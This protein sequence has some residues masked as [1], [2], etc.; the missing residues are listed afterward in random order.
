MAISAAT[1]R[2]CGGRRS[3]A[4]PGYGRAVPR[5][6]PSAAS[7]PGRTRL[8]RPARRPGPPPSFTTG[9]VSSRH[10]AI[11]PSSRSAARRAGTCTDQ[12]SRCSSTSI[13]G[14]RVLHPEP[15][16]D[17]VRDPGQRPALIQIAGRRR[18]RIQHR[19]QL[20]Q[21]GGS[22]HALRSGRP[23]GGQRRPAASAQGPP[24]P[25]HRHPRHPEPLRDLPVA[26][27]VSISSAAA[28][29]TCS[30]RDRSAAVS[31]PPSG[32][33]MPPAYPTA[34]RSSGPVTPAIEGR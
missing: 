24:P 12:P 26:G 1:T 28:S 31:P 22:E 2:A 17:L 7:G 19:L 23:F 13:P 15:P 11:L 8:R 16:P 10:L 20:T 4:P 3:P 29:R 21:L 33:L 30:R 14:Q 18:A 25:V 34:C 9:Q 32:Y 27:P 6:V 5:Y